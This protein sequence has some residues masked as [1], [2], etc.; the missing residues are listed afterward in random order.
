MLKNLQILV[1]LKKD[2]SPYTNKISRVT[3][4]CYIHININLL[5]FLFQVVSGDM[6]KILILTII[7][8]QNGETKLNEWLKIA[9]NSH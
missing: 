5:P 8:E 6:Q 4:C 1:C 3:E 2:F 9:E 7:F